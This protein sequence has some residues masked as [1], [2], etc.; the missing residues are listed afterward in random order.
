MEPGPPDP[1]ADPAIASIRSF[2]EDLRNAIKVAHTLLAAER[3]I[4]LS[5][6][7]R[8]VGLLCAQ[9]LDLP[10]EQGRALCDDLTALL[11]AAD[12]LTAALATPG[13]APDATRDVPPDVPSGGR[14][15]APPG[16]HA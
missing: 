3:T 9:T 8:Q 14:P 16:G 5:G 6:F 13:P 15:G 2:I 11:A 4:D 10:P 12:A 7:D 1:P